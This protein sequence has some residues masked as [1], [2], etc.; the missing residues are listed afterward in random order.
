MKI[1][2]SDFGVTTPKP[3]ARLV[4]FVS[5]SPMIAGFLKNSNQNIPRVNT[6]GNVEVVSTNTQENTTPDVP[7]FNYLMNANFMEIIN[8][9]DNG[10]SSSSGIA[11]PMV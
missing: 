7:I 4:S 3:P 10:G 5:A 2:T 11:M 9:G 6:N 1:Y 8:D